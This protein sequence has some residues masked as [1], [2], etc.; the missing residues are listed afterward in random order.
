MIGKGD[1]YVIPKSIFF[2]KKIYKFHYKDKL[3]NPKMYRLANKYKSMYL[4]S[5]KSENYH[6]IPN[7]IK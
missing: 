6:T 2:S 5:G 4:T 1:D 7:I 3:Q